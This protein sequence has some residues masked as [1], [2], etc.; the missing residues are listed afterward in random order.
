[1]TNEYLTAADQHFFCAVCRC[2]PADFKVICPA[3]LG[4]QTRFDLVECADC[5]TRQ[6]F[7]L[8]T[9]AELENFYNTGYYGGDWYKQRG[10]GKTFAQ[11]HLPQ[12]EN[13]KYLE[14]GCGLGYFL[15]GIRAAS[16]WQV[17]GIEFGKESVEHA[18]QKLN[19]DVRQGELSEVNFAA[20]EFDFIRICNVLEHVKDPLLMLEE[21]RRII[22]PDGYL[23]LSIPNGL[24]D[25]Q[26]LVNFYES[27]KTPPLSKDGHLFFFPKET[28]LRM[29]EKTDFEVAGSGTISIRRGL[30][31]LGKYPQKSNWKNPFYAA[32]KDG[33]PPGEIR[34]SREK[35]RPAIYYHFRRL[36]MTARMFSG[37]RDYGLEFKLMLKPLKNKFEAGDNLTNS[38]APELSETDEKTA[39][40]NIGE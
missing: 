36:A 40:N 11:W 25:S 19:L 38:V 6:L 31:T 8:P 15:D 10:W 4:R 26:S 24:T 23:H 34:L 12:K 32:N 22:K 29:L 21:C 3:T 2:E 33:E 9:N 30:R 35:K 1:M 39:Q 27:E 28:L 5:L 7:P 20:R 37:L 18:R 17:C 14:V 13:A 16:R